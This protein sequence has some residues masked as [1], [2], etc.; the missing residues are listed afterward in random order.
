MECVYS[1]ILIIQ[2]D[3]LLYK[4]EAGKNGAGS[5]RDRGRGRE[6]EEWIKRV[7]DRA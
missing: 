2:I 3:F 1:I 6:R 4:T 7:R 5:K